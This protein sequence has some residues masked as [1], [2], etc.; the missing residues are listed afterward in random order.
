MLLELIGASYLSHHLNTKSGTYNNHNRSKVSVLDQYAI[1]KQRRDQQVRIESQKQQKQVATIEKQRQAV[2]K[3]RR[4]KEEASSDLKYYASRMDDLQE[5]V[6]LIDSQLEVARKNLEIDRSMNQYG[7]VVSEK[8]I[9]DHI[10]V[11]TKL[12]KE[13]LT[14]ENQIHALEKKIARAQYIL[15]S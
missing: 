2:E 3:R 12:Q 4:Q 7:A 11:F 14:I 9:S 5:M 1:E 10:K 15:A 6:W 8:T 13:A